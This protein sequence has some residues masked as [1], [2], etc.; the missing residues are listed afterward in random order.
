MSLELARRFLPREAGSAAEAVLHWKATH[1]DAPVAAKRLNGG[2]MLYPGPGVPWGGAVAIG[3]AAPPD[4]L[5]NQLAAFYAPFGHSPRVLVSPYADPKLLEQLE[6]HGFRA[7]WFRHVMVRDGAPLPAAGPTPGVVVK[8][9]PES[10]G[11]IAR[12]FME[13]ADPGEPELHIERMF[14]AQPTARTYGAT[15]DGR[16]AGGGRMS[17]ADGLALLFG[18]SVLPDARRRGVHTAL[19]QARIDAAVAAGCDTII[20]EGAPGSATERNAVRFDFRVAFTQ[21]AFGRA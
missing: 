16:P 18:A 11:L 1:P 14:A 2:W 19:M 9:R 20:I 3:L 15:L 12:G 10:G 6:A 21:M 13:G 7:R 4:D 17:I 5:I 8:R